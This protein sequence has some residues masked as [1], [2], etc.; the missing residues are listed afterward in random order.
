MGRLSNYERKVKPRLA[1]VEA[2]ARDGYTDKDIA[3]ILTV[4]ES[5]LQT[6]KK[7]HFELAE[8]LK[9]GR[10]AD[11]LVENQFFKSCIGYKVKVKVP[12][13]MRIDGE[14]QIIEYDEERY[15]PPNVK[16]QSLWLR[17]RMSYKWSD[18]KE[19]Q[20]GGSVRMDEADRALLENV[21]AVVADTS[22]LG[23][24]GSGNDT[25]AKAVGEFKAEP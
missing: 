4:A 9:A 23:R 10:Y 14:E 1:E 2:W 8:A 24:S 11:I 13:K 18:R 12:I 6:Y 17:N 15:I 20:V 22:P 25:Y 5:T 7:E 19:V 3:K 21:Q 16:A